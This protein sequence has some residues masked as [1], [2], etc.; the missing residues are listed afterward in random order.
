MKSISLNSRDIQTSMRLDGSFHL[1]AAVLIEK[2]IIK[3]G[4]QSLSFYADRIFTAGRNKRVYTTKNFGYPY[5]SNSNV[6]SQNPFSNCKYNSTKYG[7]DK[8]A[9]LEEGMIVTGRVGAIGQTA[10]ITKEFEEKKAMGSD[11]IIRIV[12]KDKDIN[13][14]LYAYLAS[15]IGNTFLWKHAT[16]GV[17]PYI[18]EEMVGSIPVPIFPVDKQKQIHELILKS[19][20]LRVEANL[21]LEDAEKILLQGLN[22]DEQDGKIFDRSEKVISNVFTIDKNNI[23]T[24]SLRARNYSPRKQI[25]LGLCK[26][27]KYDNL[28]DVLEYAPFYGSRFKRIEA[29]KQ[30]IELLSQGDIFDSKPVGRMISKR[31]IKNIQDELVKKGTILIPAQGT[32]GENEI[33]ARAKFVWG[34]LEN[35]LV[36]GH[37]MRFVPN[38]E[39]IGSGYLFAVLSSKMW[40][41]L[42]RNSVYGTNLLGFIIPFLNDYPI[43]RFDNGIEQII[44][45]KVKTAY[46]K[47]SAS[48]DTENQAI[49][50]VENEIEQWQN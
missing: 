48:I 5:L 34:Y 38:T 44:D 1:S 25:I 12:S 13:G 40:F 22:I 46:E 35:K 27:G 29:S 8:N 42:L 7:Y 50:L 39:K 4:F 31:N 9:I 3:R 11:N 20:D 36:A 14:F 10:Y 33:F 18:N 49:Q 45:E 41:R 17:Q 6:I 16:G 21:L 2:A 15:K 28:I 26:N 24:L 32:L 23:S 19:A 37:A 47:F 30:N 43:P